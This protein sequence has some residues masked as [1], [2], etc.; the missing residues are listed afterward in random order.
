MDT[1]PTK[2]QSH[3]DLEQH[4]YCTGY[5]E[6]ESDPETCTCNCHDHYPR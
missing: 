5:T 2:D 1:E 3:C 6:D 4:D